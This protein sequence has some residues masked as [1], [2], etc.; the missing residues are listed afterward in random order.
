MRSARVD[1]LPARSNSAG[2]EAMVTTITKRL[3]TERS[4]IKKAV[5]SSG[6]PHGIG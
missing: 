3:G 4:A 6:Q 2:I 1:G 5:I